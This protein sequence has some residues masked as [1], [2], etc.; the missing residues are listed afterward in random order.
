MTPRAWRKS[1]KMSQAEA[2]DAV[3]V[4]GRNPARTWQR[5]ESGECSPPVIVMAKI[6]KLSGGRV[7]LASWE[8][9]L[10]RK[11]LRRSR[12]DAEKDD[13]AVVTAAE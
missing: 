6:E 13:V 11:I 8:E 10:R 7:T 12:E 4:R 5:W 1:N 9:A 3:G 2:A